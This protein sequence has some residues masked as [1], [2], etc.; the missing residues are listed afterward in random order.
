LKIANKQIPF[1]LEQISELTKEYPTPF[2]VYDEKAIRESVRNLYKAFSWNNG[3][4]LYFP[5]KANANPHLFKILHEEGANADCCS[6]PELMIA[7][8][9]NLKGESIILTSNDTGSAEFIKAMD[10]RTIINLDD[11]NHLEYLENIKGLPEILCLRYNPGPIVINGK[12]T[13]GHLTEDK[14][15]MTK[16]QI[17]QTYKTAKEKGIKRFG[18][19]MM[20]MSN[21]IHSSHIIDTVDFCFNLAEELLIK[22]GVELEFIDL[23]G[24]IGIPYKPSQKAIDINIISNQIKEKYFNLIQ[25]SNIKPFKIFLE[26]GRLVIGPH[27]YLVSKV[28]HVKKSYKTYA[29]LDSSMADLMRPGMYGSYHHRLFYG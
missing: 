22:H 1:T 26:T 27:G 2:Y 9:N 6:I 10:L 21:D 23:G 29:G 16:D 20:I 14:F 18:L 28:R 4:K 8:R 13:W 12:E 24:G 25:K 19:H 7:E 15:G 17:I 11:P 3:F 5:I